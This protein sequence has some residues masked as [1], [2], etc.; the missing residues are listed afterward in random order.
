[1]TNKMAKIKEQSER[2]EIIM[3]LYSRNEYETLISVLDEFKEREQ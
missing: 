3:G 2:Y 1:M